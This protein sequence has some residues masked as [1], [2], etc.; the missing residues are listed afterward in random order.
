VS[1][2]NFADDVHA[3]VR[4]ADD[5][6]LI[7]VTSYNPAEKIVKIQIPKAIAEELDMNPSGSYIARDILWKDVEVG[8]DSNFSFEV[9]LKPYSSFIFKI[10]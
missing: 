8:F 6:R 2:G 9:K 3:F 1:A 4:F 10:K 5:E 7:I